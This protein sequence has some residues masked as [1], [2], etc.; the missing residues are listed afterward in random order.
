MRLVFGTTWL[1]R[2]A[3]QSPGGTTC[4]WLVLVYEYTYMT[5]IHICIYKIDMRTLKGESISYI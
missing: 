5:Y 4:S 2:A 3:T 1:G